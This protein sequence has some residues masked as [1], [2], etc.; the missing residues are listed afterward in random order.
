[1]PTMEIEAKNNKYDWGIIKREYVEG[2]FV[3]DNIIKWPTM[4]ELALKWGVAPN[5]LRRVASE[6]RWTIEKK[7]YITNYEHTKQEE[8]IRYLAKKSAKF[9]TRCAK[10]AEEGIRRIENY[11]IQTENNVIIDK[12]GQS[13]KIIITLQDLEIAAKTLEKFQKIGRLA[14][15]NTTDNKR[16]VKDIN[17]ITFHEGLDITMQQIESNPALKDSIEEEFI[18]K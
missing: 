14:F 16:E 18:D 4:K 2:Y 3:D 5:Y 8:K 9:D 7:N 6:D 13:I 11:L 17:I 1:M 15:G 12:D 10:I